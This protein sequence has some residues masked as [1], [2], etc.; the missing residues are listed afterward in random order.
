M[1][2]AKEAI[3]KRE[4]AIDAYS[5]AISINPNFVEAYS[6]M[7]NALKDQGKL[8]STYKHTSHFYQA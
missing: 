7:G 8:K 3:G 2:A 5:K 4:E 6:N 1:G